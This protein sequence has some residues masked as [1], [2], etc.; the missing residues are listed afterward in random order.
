MLNRPKVF[1][2]QW[3]PTVGVDLIKEYCDVDHYEGTVPLDKEQFIVRAADADAL[4]VFVPDVIDAEILDHCPRVKVISSFGKGYDNIDI[5]ECSKRGILVTVNPDALTDSTADLA[6]GLLLALSRNILLGDQHVRT[7]P[8]SGWHATNLLGRDFHHAK[9]GI[10]GLGAIGEAIAKRAK[11]FEV[12]MCYTD[13][14]TYPEKELRLSI[15]YTD[16]NTLLQTCD[17][18]I[19]A[20]NLTEK[21]YH[22]IGK[23]QLMMMKKGSYLINISRGSIVD[24][25]A[26]EDALKEG[27]LA[28]YAADVFEFED[29]LTPHR[30]AFISEELLS[31]STKTVFTPHIGTGTIEA[32][33]RLARSSVN[34]LLAALN[35][36]RPTGAINWLEL[37]K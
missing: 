33:E 12:E 1:I 14:Y 32:R 17:Y 8:F 37:V 4:L 36:E 30:P 27:H 24:E 13:L 23:E 28:G 5:E 34:Q 35:G 7:G 25:V 2:S 15:H 21:T 29:P 26:V 31:Q 18:V 6:I 10:I 19:V 20:V 9:V 22:L 16:L 11:G 3:M